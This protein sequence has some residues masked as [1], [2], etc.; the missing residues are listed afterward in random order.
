MDTKVVTS[1][2]FYLSVHVITFY[3][4]FFPLRTII[5]SKLSK[6]DEGLFIGIED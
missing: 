6:V 1:E 2:T 4:I 3:G 5:Q